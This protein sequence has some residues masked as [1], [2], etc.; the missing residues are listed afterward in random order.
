MF[1]DAISSTA[2][3]DSKIT[4]M[5]KT[6]YQKLDSLRKK[7]Q[8]KCKV[9]NLP[10]SDIKDKIYIP[11]DSNLSQIIALGEKYFHQRCK[12]EP[13][14]K[15]NLTDLLI[16][17]IKNTAENLL[18]LY[19]Y[20]T[21]DNNT[22]DAILN[23]LDLLNKTKVQPNTINEW[24][25]NLVQLNLNLI[26]KLYRL[27][28][29]RFGPIDKT[30]VNLSTRSGHAILVSGTNLNDIY[31]LLEF[32]KNENIDIYTHDN[33]IIAHGFQNIK[34]YK[35]LIGHFGNCTENCILDFAVFPG[36]ILI[37]RN[38]NINTDYL[39]RGRIFTTAA[40]TPGVT[41][42]ASGVR[43]KRVK[44]ATSACLRPI[45]AMRL[46]ITSALPATLPEANSTGAA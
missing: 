6:A 33:L 43:G 44:A 4:G 16:L 29:E 27:Q 42:S 8:E 31:N 35:N 23:S 26:E 25:L 38:S 32:T 21:E 2:Y 3:N 41:P 46:R 28:K 45:W 22:V 13:K 1:A 15:R 12:Q 9:L 14:D 7:Y 10:K 24:I 39:Y 20:N 40:I 34:K 18:S 37:T 19:E 5:I 36:A 17:I 30:T 11:H